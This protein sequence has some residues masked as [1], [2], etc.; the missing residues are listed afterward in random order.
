MITAYKYST[1]PFWYATGVYWTIIA[2]YY[3][4]S[5]AMFYRKARLLDNI[6]Q[7]I[8]VG[9]EM[10]PTNVNPIELR[11]QELLDTV[12][13]AYR[14][15]ISEKDYEY[16]DML[17]YYTLWAHQ[18]KT[19]IAAMRLLLQQ[20]K[21][22][23]L[24]QD[25]SDELFRVEQYVEMVLQYVR[26]GRISNDLVIEEL[27][28]DSI[29]KQAINKYTKVFIRKKISLDYTNV[30][31]KVITDEKWL[32]FVIEQIL[33]NSLKY[34]KKGTVKIYLEPNRE[35][36]LVIEDSGIGIKEE[37]LPR[38]FEKGYTG[39]NGR[40]DKKS[41]G[42]GLY[43]SKTILTQLSHSI[44]V[45]STVQQGTRVLIDLHSYPLRD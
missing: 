10:L 22:T 15:E 13:E 36:V 21:Q 25:I 2:F 27:D 9:T 7:Q 3:V 4:F 33:S 37:D 6:K 14:K 38:I 32:L 20:E 45:D 42:I 1:E 26:I 41:T 39:Y 31:T 18:I 24:L 34:T 5:F 23:K 28:L 8:L 40:L 35:K 17:D 16:A 29:I 43:L 19:P 44:T 12:I 30:N 11:Y